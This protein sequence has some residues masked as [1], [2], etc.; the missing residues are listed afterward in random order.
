MSH[1]LNSYNLAIAPSIDMAVSA[2]LPLRF[3]GLMCKC[4][5]TNLNMMIT[6]DP[7]S[8]GGTDFVVLAI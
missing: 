8:A 6:T 4:F 3:A 7:D 5:Y 2:A 1:A